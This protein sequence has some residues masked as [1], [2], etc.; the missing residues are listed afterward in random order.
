MRNI[1]YVFV[2]LVV[3]SG[4]ANP[5]N[6]R[7]ATNYFQ[8]GDSALA[9]GDLSHAKE[10]F[11]RALVNVRLGHMGA[12]AE[13]QVH[14]KLGRTQGNMCEYEEAEKHFIEAVSLNEKVHGNESPLTFSSKL[15]L[16]QFSYDIGWYKKSVEYFEQAF[17]VGGDKLKES[18]PRTY[19]EVLKDYGDSLSKSGSTEKSSSINKE[20]KENSRYLSQESSYVRYPTECK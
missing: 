12:E 9:Q 6:Q 7:T 4:C 8:Q 10:M 16:G 19:Y 1:K 11:S 14:M 3:L 2:F 20:L 17:E 15:E 5:I 13:A 18:S